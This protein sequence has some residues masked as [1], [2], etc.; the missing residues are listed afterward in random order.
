M[1][2]LNLSGTFSLWGKRHWSS[3]ASKAPMSSP[4]LE[5]NTVEVGFLKYWTGHNI[6]NNTS[7]ESES[8][9]IS[10]LLINSIR[11]MFVKIR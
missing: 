10:F 4:S 7:V 3:S 11:E 6:H 2:F 8:S 9:I 5:S 1:A